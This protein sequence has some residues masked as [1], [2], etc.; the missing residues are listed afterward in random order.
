MEQLNLP[1]LKAE[2]DPELAYCH[3]GRGFKRDWSKMKAVLETEDCC[4]C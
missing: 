1:I 3:E 4:A 2:R